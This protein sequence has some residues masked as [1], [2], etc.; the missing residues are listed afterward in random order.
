[1][2]LG[3]GR[4]TC[5]RDFWGQLTT[6][7]IWTVIEADI[8]IVFKSTVDQIKHCYIPQTRTLGVEEFRAKIC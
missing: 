2:F 5:E 3:S 1:M 6:F 8:L 7:H 4:L